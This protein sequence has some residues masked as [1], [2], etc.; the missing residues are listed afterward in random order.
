M[1]WLQ[2]LTTEPLPFLASLPPPHPGACVRAYINKTYVH[3]GNS[4]CM[5]THT[6]THTDKP[7]DYSCRFVTPFRFSA[8]AAAPPPSL[9][10]SPPH[11]FPPYLLRF[12][13]YWIEPDPSL[14]SE[15]G[16]GPRLTIICTCGET[17]ARATGYA[18][19]VENHLLF[20]VC[21]NEKVASPKSQ[22][23][24]SHQRL[25]PARHRGRRCH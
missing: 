20:R 1:S 16:Q 5:H 7:D 22:C 14:Q 10:P 3:I 13:A 17:L 12:P 15:Q 23:L 2:E 9:S 18:M 4:A 8:A 21:S 6:P 25:P 24:P 11:L 19:S